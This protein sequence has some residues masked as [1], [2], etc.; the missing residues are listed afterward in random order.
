VARGLNSSGRSDRSG[1][2]GTQRWGQL[3]RAVEMTLMCMHDERHSAGGP[4]GA[5]SGRFKSPVGRIVGR[6][7]LNIQINFQLFK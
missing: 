4:D 7:G 2:V 5:A 3:R 1:T 6:P